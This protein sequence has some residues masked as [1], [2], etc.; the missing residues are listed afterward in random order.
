MGKFGFNKICYLF[1]QLLQG[2]GKSTILHTHNSNSSSRSNSYESL[3]QFNEI[4]DICYTS[5]GSIVIHNNFLLLQLMFVHVG[6]KNLLSL[7]NLVSW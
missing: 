4:I 3:I 5:F 2:N 7:Y 6:I 1:L